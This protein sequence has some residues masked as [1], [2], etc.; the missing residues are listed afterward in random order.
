[1]VES[2]AKRSLRKVTPYAADSKI[3]GI[4][5]DA[6]EN[7]N[8]AFKLNDK[9][10]EAIMALDISRYPDPEAKVLK[11]K[12]AADNWINEECVIVG[13]GSD[14]LILMMIQAFINEG[15]K[16]VTPAPTFSM[17]GISNGIA[18]GET[19]QVD[20]GEFFSFD[21]YK[22]IKRVN[23]EEPKLIFI[24]NPNNPT[25]GM[26]D[27]EHIIKLL[28][29][30]KG[31]VVIDE[32]Y[33]EFSG[34]TVMDLVPY[35]PKLVVLRT[36]SKAYGL[37]GARVGYGVASKEII[38][39]LKK[40]KPPYNLSVLDQQAAIICLQ[41]KEIFQ[42]SIEEILEE[43]LW[44]TKALG[45]FPGVEVFNSYGNFL[46]IRLKGAKELYNYL[47]SK[48]I[49]IRHFNEGGSL[50]NCLRVTVGT[51]E[52]NRAFIGSL[53]EWMNTLKI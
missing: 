12:I 32:A 51:K 38:G 10:A 1:M 9:I 2:L 14:Q 17:Y 21:F 29:N 20:M 47:Q 3:K 19:I 24:S 48:G 31:I 46:L 4:P 30:F 22:F 34:R 26:V 11:K 15:D 6:N 49:F 44:L 7:R 25:G 5:L 45:S 40:V 27:R 52:E 18:G 16:I 50:A 53:K 41:N 37:A 35:Y 43:R 28:E 36:L 42:P 23:K 33:Y 8:L 39:I 13:S